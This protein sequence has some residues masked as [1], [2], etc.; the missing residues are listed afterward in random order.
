MLKRLLLALALLSCA[1]PAQA[2][3]NQGFIYEQHNTAIT[4]VVGSICGSA[5]S[6]ATYAVVQVQGANANFT[7]N[8]STPSTSNGFLLSQN[9][10]LPIYGQTLI[11][12]FQVIGSGATLNVVCTQ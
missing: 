2:A 6:P 10:F 8:G 11:N 7:Y 4:S 1:L 12:G 5:S 9:Y 3:N